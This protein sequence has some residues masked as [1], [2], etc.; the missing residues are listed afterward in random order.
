MTS[1]GN[2]SDHILWVSKEWILLTTQNIIFFCFSQHT[3]GMIAGYILYR[4]KVPPKIPFIVN[5]G[6][7]SASLFTL[8]IIIF[9]VQ[10]G[11]LGVITTSF[12][13]SLGHTGN[14]VFPLKHFLRV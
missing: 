8:F 2:D 14:H 6:L 5:V 3:P 9:G 11:Q 10:G 4:V 7:W 12:Y 1:H 13:V